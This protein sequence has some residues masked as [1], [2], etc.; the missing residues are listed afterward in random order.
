M[1]WDCGAGH[2]FEL[3]LRRRLAL[4]IFPFLVT[5]AKLIGEFYNKR[6]SVA[7]GCPRFAYSFVFVMLRQ[8]YWRCDL[9]SA[10]RRSAANKKNPRKLLIGAANLLRFAFKRRERRS[11]NNAFYIAPIQLALHCS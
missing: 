6:R 4:N 2:Y 1:A 11:A 8:Y 10:K 7:H 5:T 3:L 9:F